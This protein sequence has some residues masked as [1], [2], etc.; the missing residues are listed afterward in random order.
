LNVSLNNTLTDYAS[1]ID[2]YVVSKSC[3]IVNEFDK[4][5]TV[6]L[7]LKEFYQC[8]F[9]IIKNACDAMPEGGTIYISTKR[10]EKKVKIFFKDNGLGIPDSVKDK[11]F[12][13]FVSYGK[14]EG[15]GLG[16]AITKKIV[17]AHNGKIE[18][19]STTG[20]GT[21]FIITLPIASLF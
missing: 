5:V 10:E 19:E 12:D 16:L 1:R 7:D 14:K 18:F 6:R 9:H 15:T 11:I 13:P 17:D 2:N 21:T 20:I 4:D 3:R 8:Y